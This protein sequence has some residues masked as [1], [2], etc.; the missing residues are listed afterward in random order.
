MIG[1]CNI[2]RQLGQCPLY[3]FQAAR[4]TSLPSAIFDAL[5]KPPLGSPI[6]VSALEQHIH[7]VSH[8][9][10]AV[11]RARRPARNPTYPSTGPRETAVGR[12]NTRRVW[13]MSTWNLYQ[14]RPHA[15]IYSIVAYHMNSPEIGKLRHIHALSNLCA[16][17][18]LPVCS[19]CSRLMIVIKTCHLINRYIMGVRVICMVCDC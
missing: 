19:L 11:S 16:T 15:F 13:Y 10:H 1:H 17:G 6:S 4:P 2:A 8:I 12:D 7:L 18:S 5:V 3:M 14:W 9:P